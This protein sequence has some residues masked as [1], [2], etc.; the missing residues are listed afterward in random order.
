[1]TTSNYERGLYKEYE[2]L[3]TKN[4]AIKAEHKILLKEH[5]ILDKELKIKE[6]LETELKI[7]KK[8]ILTILFRVYI[9]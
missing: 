4:E 1:M 6:K 7:G 2:L 3:I 5:Q 9:I 8:N